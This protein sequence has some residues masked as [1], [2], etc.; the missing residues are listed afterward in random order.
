M[1]VLRAPS[2]RGLLLGA[3]TA[4]SALLFACGGDAVDP[5][6]GPPPEAPFDVEA[7]ELAGEYDWA[8][9]RLVAS[10]TLRLSMAGGP[11]RLVALDSEVTEVKAVRTAE[12]AELPFRADRAAKR[13]EIDLP[14]PAVPGP[15]ALVVDYEAAPAL[16]LYDSP[17]LIEVPAR[18]GDP[19]ATRVVYTF[20]EPQGARQWLPG[21]DDPA[22]RA[23]FSVDLRVG[24]GES[25]VANGDLV[26]DEPAAGG[27][28]RVRY[29]TRYTLPT[30]LMAFAA[31][32]FEVATGP[33]TSGGAPLTV[34]HRPGLPGDYD[35]LLAENARLAARFEALTGTPYPF[36]KY[37]LVLLPNFPAGGEEHA[38]ITF[39]G[40]TVS[41]RPAR[42]GDRA[43][44]A[45]ELAHQWFG[46]LV[47][48]KS[49][50]DL[51][52]KEGMAS[53][54]EC[55]GTRA[56]TL[57]PGAGPYGGDC[58]GVRDGD[59]VRD[60]SLAP[61]DKYTSG[62]YGRAAWVLSQLRAVAGE[63]AFWGTWRSLLEAHR[64]GNLAT[65]EFLEAFRPSLAPAAFDALARAVD[66]KSLPRLY[67]EDLGGGARLRVDDPEGALVAPMSVAR[68]GADGAAQA[69]ELAPGAPVDL[70]PAPGTFLVPD[71]ADLHPDYGF[72]FADDASAAA[73]TTAVAA[74][75]LPQAPPLV[76]RL[77]ALPEE[78]Q[79]SLLADGALP[80]SIA[81]EAFAAFVASLDSDAARASAMRAGC[82]RALEAGQPAE[83]WAAAVEPLLRDQPNLGGLGA[84]GRY[85]SCSE[86][87]SPLTLFADDWAALG[88]GQPVPESRAAYLAKF[89]LP[90]ASAIAFW[91][92]A[93]TL[94]PSTRLR[95]LAA[96]QLAF[97]A[98][99]DDLLPAA[100]RPAW[101]AF[102]ADAVRSTEVNN[103]LVQ[104]LTLLTRT[105]G[106]TPAENAAGLEAVGQ[107]LASRRTHLVHARAVCSARLL[108]R[109]D[110]AAWA[111]FG[112]RVE[113]APLT[114]RAR[115][116]LA[117]P[118][119]C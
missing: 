68:V 76:E 55:E 93:A 50:D 4:G 3:L 32:P 85:E 15:L 46:D 102:A 37:A 24:E 97:Y 112:R 100:E 17:A 70:P 79:T 92:N 66:A 54:L 107:V 75:R 74:A 12:G 113:G 25:L 101:R 33:A 86:L 95:T 115:A 117:D 61:R 40:E 26:A 108:I 87:I 48:V 35:E 51:W 64:F 72:F 119:G 58:Q 78:H 56:S 114:P 45:H 43:L 69:V 39:Q 36:E 83:A 71:L 30:Y 57:A 49:W 38:G 19:I 8:R 42:A 34:W 116:L 62:P 1:L 28:R 103:V 110:E 60:R 98:G 13:L 31:G 2:A 10:L 52:L 81:P 41:S 47:T 118:S 59:A 109:D 14:G 44:T 84:V 16:D 91:G 7:Y 96:Q 94:G 23:L 105:A 104:L 27:G 6:P 5:P 80:P 90:P 20:S 11:E 65:D 21:R 82:N 111:D 67:V 99:R 89:L 63:E 88:S 18:A 9:G 106:A 77:A 22:D 53:L 29:A 73:W